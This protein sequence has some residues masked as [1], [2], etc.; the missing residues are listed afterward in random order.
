MNDKIMRR[1]Q[2]CTY[3]NSRDIHIHA[4]D[5]LGIIMCLCRVCGNRWGQ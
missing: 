2:R 3:C 4:P 1:L 5:E